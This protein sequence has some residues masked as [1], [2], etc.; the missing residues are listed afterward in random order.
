MFLNTHEGTEKSNYHVKKA[1]NSSNLG[2]EDN[3]LNS[4]GRRHKM[5]S[6]W[7]K[8]WLELNKL[9]HLGSNLYFGV[10]IVATWM[11]ICTFLSA[12]VLSLGFRNNEWL[13]HWLQ[14]WDFETIE[15]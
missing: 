11:F 8:I 13:K 1:L 9:N 10:T 6:D 5:T 15:N 7:V 14:L 2:S 12:C 4:S 3:D